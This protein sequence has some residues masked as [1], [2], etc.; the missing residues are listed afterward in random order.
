MAVM[1]ALMMDLI[2]ISYGF[3]GSCNFRYIVGRCGEAELAGVHH[4][5]IEM[6]LAFLQFRYDVRRRSKKHGQ[7]DSRSTTGTTPTVCIY[8]ESH[9]NLTPILSG[10][11]NPH[12]F[13]QIQAT[14]PGPPSDPR[15]AHRAP[16]P[17][18]TPGESVAV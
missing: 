17:S 13:P 7:V 8:W 14:R 6:C 12:L 10:Q 9:Q 4:R 2:C 11:P 16:I 1:M 5:R 18:T 3:N 15:C